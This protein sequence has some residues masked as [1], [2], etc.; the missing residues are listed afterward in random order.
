MLTPAE[1]LARFEERNPD[2]VKIYR[3]FNSL[4]KERI[5]SLYQEWDEYY[6]KCKLSPSAENWTEQKDAM[7]LG[8]IPKVKE[9]GLW[10][11][12]LAK[13]EKTVARPRFVDPY[14]LSHS[15]LTW[16]YK[17]LLDDYE[18]DK[19]TTSSPNPIF[20]YEESLSE[21]GEELHG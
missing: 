10:A 11:G 12:E 8:D 16:A 13:Q 5:S 4:A 20:G 14:R 6:E 3:W 9:M 7:R 15:Q 19:Q 21:G 18:R 2:F 1:R 17:T